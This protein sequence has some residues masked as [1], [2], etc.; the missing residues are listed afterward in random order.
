GCVPASSCS[1]ISTRRRERRPCTTR[2]PSGG[3]R[4]ASH[5]M[6]VTFCPDSSFDYRISW[7]N[8]LPTMSPAEVPLRLQQ[9]FDRDH[10]GGATE[11]RGA[12]AAGDGAGLGVLAHEGQG[13]VYPVR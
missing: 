9:L 6:A 8:S 10:E 13:F 3:C 11:R 7:T 1:G 4:P 12:A 2:E 5:W